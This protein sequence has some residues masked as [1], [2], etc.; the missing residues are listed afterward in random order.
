MS[1]ERR[2][3]AEFGNQNLLCGGAGLRSPA[4]ADDGLHGTGTEQD[5]EKKE[6]KQW[7]KQRS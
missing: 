6:E 2:K 7:V 4:D 3:H 1:E 5:F